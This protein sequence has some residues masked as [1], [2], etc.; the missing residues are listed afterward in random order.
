MSYP[1][2]PDITGK[3]PKHKEGEPIENF[4]VPAPI[5]SVIRHGYTV[6]DGYVWSNIPYSKET[7]L[8]TEAGESW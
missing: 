1:E 4:L 6:K 5:K 2:D 7:G 8:E 3:A